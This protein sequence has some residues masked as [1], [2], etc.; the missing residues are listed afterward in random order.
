MEN[1]GKNTIK[2]RN[3]STFAKYRRDSLWQIYI[4]AIV[5]A[6]ILLV[7][8]ALVGIGDAMSVSQWADV[9]LIWLIVPA[10]FFTLIFALVLAGLVYAFAKLIGAVPYLAYRIQEIL[11]MIRIRARQIS[12]TST[13]PIIR[14]KSFFAA[15]RA[16]FKRGSPGY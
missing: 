10:M 1:K 6:I 15:V 4:P 7:I 16:I 2:A 8:A 12:E 14:T 9:S 5:G 3:P 11:L 13:K